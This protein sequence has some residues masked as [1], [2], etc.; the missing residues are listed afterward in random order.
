MI[1]RLKII[2][3]FCAAHQLKGYRGKC[4]GMHGHNF[5]VELTVEGKKLDR[6]GLLV[7]FQELKK[8]LTEI[9]EEMD[10]K[11]LNQLP[12]FAKSN[13]SSENIARYLFGIFSGKLPQ[14]IRLKEVLVWESENAAASYLPDR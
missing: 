7:D 5:K 3:C 8:R 11:V 9:L 14:G 2:D 6:I 10:H 1:Y 13:P 12:A 4:E